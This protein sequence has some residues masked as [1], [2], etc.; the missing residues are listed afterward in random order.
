MQGFCLC[1]HYQRVEL[2]RNAPG[3]L[4]SIAAILHGLLLNPSYAARMRLIKAPRQL[5]GADA[6]VLFCRP[7]RAKK[8]RGHGDRILSKAHFPESLRSFY[9]PSSYAVKVALALG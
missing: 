9:G 8:T 1:T 5:Y 2:E 6:V 7:R 3:Q 4:F